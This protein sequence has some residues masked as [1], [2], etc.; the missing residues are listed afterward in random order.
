[1]TEAIFLAAMAARSATVA[2]VAIV[3]LR[4]LGKRQLGSM[5]I[6]DLAMIMALANAVQNAMTRGSGHLLVGVVS[7]ATLLAISA[8]VTAVVLRA[9]RTEGSLVGTP[10]LLAH[11]GQLVPAHLRQQGI[12]AEQVMTAV[13]ERGLADLSDT[14]TVT[15]EVDGTISVI[16]KQAQSRRHPHVFP[17]RLG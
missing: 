2:V 14:L 9:P 17:P 3:G 11:D 10:T 4:L 5:N 12:T 16:P 1:M 8:L 15:L 13:R 6:Y 7:A